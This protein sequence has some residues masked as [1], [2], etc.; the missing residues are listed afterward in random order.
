MA[1]KGLLKARKKFWKMMMWQVISMILPLK[2]FCEKFV[3]TKFVLIKDLVYTALI[4]IPKYVAKS[5]KTYNLILEIGKTWCQIFQFAIVG[6]SQIA[7]HVRS[8]KVSSSRRHIPRPGR[9]VGLGRGRFCRGGGAL[10]A[11]GSVRPKFGFGIGNRNQGPILVLEQ[12][13]FLPKPKLFF[14][15]F[16]H[17]F[18]ILRGIQVFISLKMNPDLKI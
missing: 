17:F 4:A 2:Q 6:K 3:L 1:S 8:S 9:R 16:S 7:S 5:K 14:S 15:N 10:G 11:Q 13:N 18:P 12:K